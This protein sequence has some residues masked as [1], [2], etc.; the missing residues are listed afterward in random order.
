MN[1]VVNGLL[2]DNVIYNLQSIALSLLANLVGPKPLVTDR[3][4]Y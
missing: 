1:I 2:D 4:H 3:Y